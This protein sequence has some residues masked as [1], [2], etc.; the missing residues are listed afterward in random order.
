M[1]KR[2]K[3]K[4]KRYRILLL[5]AI[6]TIPLF[7]MGRRVYRLTD[8]IFEEKSLDKQRVI[9]QAEN[10]VLKKRIDEYRKG[11]LVETKAREDLG[12]IKKGE[13]VYLIR[14]R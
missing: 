14:K 13:K 3:Q 11:N 1:K 4:S 9:L 5:G 8:A 12:M 10:D 2:R 7:Y 6:L